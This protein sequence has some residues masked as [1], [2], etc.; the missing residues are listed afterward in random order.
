MPR[1]PINGLGQGDNPKS[2][3]PVE[4]NTLFMISSMN[5][6]SGKKETYASGF[7]TFTHDRYSAREIKASQVC[8]S[9]NIFSILSL[10]FKVLIL[11]EGP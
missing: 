3:I 8:L 10:L 1:S 4:W 7:L 5:T 2:R 9:E 11:I 6:V